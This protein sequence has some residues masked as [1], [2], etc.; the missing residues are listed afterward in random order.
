VALLVAVAVFSHAGELTVKDGETIAFLGDSITAGGAAH[1]NYCRL[2]IH[3]LKTKGIRTT[4]VFAGI[5]GNKSSDM[6]LRLGQVL[7]Q[8]P[9]H[10]FLSAGVNDIWHGA[11]DVRIGVFKPPHEGMGVDLEHY[12]IYM[13]QILDRCEEAGV[14][15]ILSTITPIKE[16]PEFKLNKIAR[17]Y[18]AFLYEQA[19]NRRLRVARLH[20]ELFARIAE[21]NA[22]QGGAGNRNVL[23]SDG[24]HP[25]GSGH[26]AM[27][28]GI[29][30]AMGLSD[31]DLEA[32]E[33]EW[34]NS[35]KV[36][37]VGDRRVNAGSRGGGWVN[38]VLDGLNAGRP[39]V[40]ASRV[41]DRKTLPLGQLLS[42]LDAAI[43]KDR[44]KY[45]L[46]VPP[47]GDAQA[48]TA[49]DDYKKT[50]WTVIEVA[51]KNG[52]KLVV[53]TI[54]M[55]DG[56]S[57][58]EAN[59]ALRPYNS[60]IR[61]LCA[62][63]KVVLADVAADMTDYY[64]ATPGSK[65]TV[66]DDRLNHTGGKMLAECVLEKFGEADESISSLRE[67]WDKGGS[68]TFKYGGMVN[69]SVPL[70]DD[71]K[72][73]LQEISGRFHRLGSSKFLEMGVFLLLEGDDKENE[74]R[75]AYFDKNWL[76]TDDSGEG[77]SERMWPASAAQKLAIAEYTAK[78]EIDRA[79][80]YKR[81]YKVGMYVM[82]KENPLGRGSY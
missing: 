70:S 72:K 53:T 63:N 26:Q 61:Q 31:T 79:E 38:M 37:I 56:G 13:S 45:M 35:P 12:K 7:K 75:I 33:K 73:A 2:V 62:K 54:P 34:N 81:A 14:K 27:A 1:G 32:V 20:E 28:K 22:E 19:K 17:Q 60:A 23:T 58:A 16:D 40:T 66:G 43:D 8:K 59:V 5:P 71:G 68:Y 52:L 50:L 48:R 10:L 39:M 74:K 21:L 3:G 36:L 67:I 11:V 29:L 76:A 78:H 42:K 30:R 9:D 47:L 77:K 65:L 82:R 55:V 69:F 44:T 80:F 57:E 51:K 41:S 64:K 24:V 49:L 6:L 18:N 15:V 46:L 4:G 25:T